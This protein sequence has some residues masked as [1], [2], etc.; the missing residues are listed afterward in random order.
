MVQILICSQ[1]QLRTRVARADRRLVCGHSENEKRH[2]VTAIRYKV[3]ERHIVT[4]ERREKRKENREKIQR[5]REIR[6]LRRPLPPAIA[7]I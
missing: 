2:I 5:E 4:T 1:A 6:R 7:A 3:T